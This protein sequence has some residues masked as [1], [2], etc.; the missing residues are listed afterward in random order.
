[1][2]ITK[3]QSKRKRKIKRKIKI[4]KINRSRSLRIVQIPTLIKRKGRRILLIRVKV[5]KYKIWILN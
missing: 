4:K 3:S 1:M 2:K 5:R